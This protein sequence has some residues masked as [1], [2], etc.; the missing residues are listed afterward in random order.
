MLPEI[1]LM[2]LML[3]FFPQSSVWLEESIN[4]AQLQD[5]EVEEEAEDPLL[6]QLR[7]LSRK[8]LRKRRLVWK[9]LLMYSEEISQ[10]IIKC[11]LNKIEN[12][13]V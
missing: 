1:L 8:S 7:L 9:M 12:I 10:E 2:L 11:D 4:S 5:L 3:L 13:I 6:Q